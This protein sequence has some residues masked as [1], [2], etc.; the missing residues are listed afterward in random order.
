MVF[1]NIECGEI[2]PVV[3]D[4]R[5]I[6]N[7]KAQALKDG[8]D[9]FANKTMGWRL[10]RKWVHQA[11]QIGF[12]RRLHLL[13][14]VA[15]QVGLTLQF[16]FRELFEIIHHLSECLTLFCGTS[17]ISPIRFLTKPFVPK[18]GYEM[19]PLPFLRMQEGAYFRLISRYFFQQLFH[20]AKIRFIIYEMLN[21]DGFVDSGFRDSDSRFNSSFF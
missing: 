16:R 5:T 6:S 17:F 10:P 11:A 15:V 8:N 4:L 14:I 9:P 19:L 21:V 12:C 7:G 20:G 13:A 3:F 1:V 2:V 18:S